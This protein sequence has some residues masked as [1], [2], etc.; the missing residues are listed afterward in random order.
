[1][2]AGPAADLTDQHGVDSDADHNEKALQ[3]KS[4]KTAQ[5]ILPHLPPFVVGHGSKRDCSN[6]AV[7][8]NFH[9]AAYQ[10]QHDAKGYNRRGDAE[11]HRF[12][13]QP[14]QLPDL[15]CLQLRRYVAENGGEVQAGRAADD[16]GALL[17]DMLRHVK[18]RHSDVKGVRDKHHRDKR[19][20]DP[21]VE[22]KGFK[23]VEVVAVDNHGDK[24]IAQNKREY[25][26]R[27]W[28]HH[29]IA[30]CA[31]HGEYPGVPCRRGRPHVRR[32]LPDLCVDLVE[33]P[34]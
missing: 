30:E 14:Q 34:G 4:R 20:N 32:D 28:H 23:I 27:D 17:D 8:I 11:H 31:Y 26:T 13:H 1:M 15:H 18:Y 16:T 24:L 22:N 6:G 7:D 2:Q 5:V 25:H 29:I 19:F 12:H 9:H 10:D 21:L 3:P 33:H